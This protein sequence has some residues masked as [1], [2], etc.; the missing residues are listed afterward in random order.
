MDSFL[1]WLGE[2][3]RG[4]W[5]GFFEPAA[6]LEQVS[7]ERPFFPRGTAARGDKARHRDRLGLSRAEIL[8]RC[9]RLERAEALFWTLGPK[10]V[11]K[12][13]IAGWRELLVAARADDQV[14][15]GIWP[16][17]DPSLEQLLGHHDVVLAETYPAGLYR[18]VGVVFRSGQGGKTSH[19]ARRAQA[20]ALIRCAEG[21]GVE[22]APQLRE[23]IAAGFPK[24]VG[25]DDGFDAA[26]GLLGML[27]VLAGE[28]PGALPRDDAVL[29]VEGWMLGLLPTG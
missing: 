12:A 16:F 29:S 13:A 18:R 3:G 26:V 19:D 7:I 4:R 27:D 24:E 25:G 5:A 1:E 10:Q 17:D 8:R 28:R 2:L 14:S 23:A 11:G 9:D 6:T 15:V 21:L 20:A 22:L